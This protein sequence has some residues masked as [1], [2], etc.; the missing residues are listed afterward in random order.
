MQLF[1]LCCVA[2]QVALQQSDEARQV[3]KVYARLGMC[4][5][6]A[7]TVLSAKHTQ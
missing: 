4:K 6:R 2:I 5:W 3:C 7:L 1:L